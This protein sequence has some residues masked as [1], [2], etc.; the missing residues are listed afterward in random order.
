MGWAFLLKFI[1]LF[2]ECE[3]LIWI[4]R[5][6]IELFVFNFICSDVCKGCHC[7]VTPDY[8][9]VRWATAAGSDVSIISQHGALVTPAGCNRRFAVSCRRCSRRRRHSAT[10][11]AVSRASLPS[12]YLA[13]RR[14]DLSRRAVGLPPARGTDCYQRTGGKTK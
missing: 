7:A 8:V 13:Q 12:I 14:I 9:A 3:F 11:A 1:C 4:Y 6:F 10:S 5:F 2:T